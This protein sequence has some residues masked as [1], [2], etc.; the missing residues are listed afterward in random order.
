MRANIPFV[1]SIGVVM[2]AAQA[3]LA[4]LYGAWEF[5]QWWAD[6]AKYLRRV[7]RRWDAFV[8]WAAVMM[9]GFSV[10]LALTY[11]GWPVA[12]AVALSIALILGSASI[13]A[14]RKSK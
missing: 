3:L 6:P 9:G 10:G 5:W 8:E 7:A 1:W 13:M 11:G 4:A 2:L 12:L 14:R